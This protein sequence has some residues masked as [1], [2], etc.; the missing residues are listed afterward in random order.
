MA[1]GEERLTP[2]MATPKPSDDALLQAAL[3][4]KTPAQMARLFEIPD[5]RVADL[6]RD[7]LG[8]RVSSGAAHGSTYT[9]RDRLVFDTEVKQKL[10]EQLRIEF[11]A[12]HLEKATHRLNWFETAGAQGLE[13][14]VGLVDLELGHNSYMQ[15]PIRKFDHV[16]TIAGLV[17]AAVVAGF[18]FGILFPVFYV[19]KRSWTRWREAKADRPTAAIVIGYLTSPI[20]FVVLIPYLLVAAIRRLAFVLRAR[21]AAAALAT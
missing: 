10:Y 7:R 5:R 1:I 16:M 9:W 21:R 19:A 20:T 18:T 2:P 14:L 11:G 4:C 12:E 13:A 17:G 3:N 8:V 6:L 15:Q